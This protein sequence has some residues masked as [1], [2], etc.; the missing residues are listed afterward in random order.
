MT[1]IDTNEPAVAATPPS[2]PLAELARVLGVA[3][4]YWDWQGAHV[5]VSAETIVAVLAALG[6]QADTPQAVERGLRDA[7]LAPWRRTLPSCVLGRQSRSTRIPVH[8]PHGSAVVVWIETESRAGRRSVTQVEHHVPPRDVDGI[9]T[10][11]A[12]FEIPPGFPIGWHELHAQVGGEDQIHVPLMIV[13]ERLELPPHVETHGAFGL[14]TQMYAMRSRASWGIG[15]LGDLAD[16]TAW[17]A[18]DLGADFVLINP[19]H[20]AEPVAPMEPSPYLPTT[21]RFV[22]PIYI[23]VEDVAEVAYLPPGQRAVMEEYATQARALTQVDIIDRDACWDL[24]CRALRMVYGARRAPRRQLAFE[25]FCER[26]GQGLV[27]FATWCAFVEEYG[28]DPDAWPAGLEDA[29]GEAVEAERER[30]ADNVRFHMWLQWVVDHQLSEVQRQARAAGMSIGVMQDLAV[31]VHP[32][33]ADRWGLGDALARGVTVGAPPDPYNQRGQDWSQP[34]WRPDRL[35]DLGYEPFRAMIRAALRHSGALRIDHIIGLF[36]L[37]WVPEGLGPT[38][39]TYVRYDHEA[40]IGILVLEAQRAGAVVVGEDLGTVE[41]WVRDVLSERGI[42]GTSILWFEREDD[43]APKAPEDYRRLCLASVT[44][45][46][47]PPT[48]GYLAGEHIDVR[49]RLDLFT[50]PVEVERA[51]DEADRAR[52]LAV[53]RDRGLIHEDQSSARVVEALH[54][55]LSWTPSLLI[56]LSVPDLVGDLR[57]INQPGTHNEYPNWRLP[58]AGSDR[59]P[60]LLEELMAS[61]SVRRITRALQRG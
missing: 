6:V 41:P 12:M 56:G 35:A 30:L 18:H 36:R 45:H 47:L 3:T 59:R 13:P 8:V 16:L 22:N 5:V 17:G 27:D 44:T 40:L 4:E 1:S 60:V 46:D 33:G 11:E 19:V 48:A 58:V 25:M 61:R 7:D 23:R 31:G 28:V 49:A 52:M 26:E 43:G 9:L 38:H 10:G 2:G 55:Y 21:R 57:T 39:G 29:H 53:L 42:L 34:P 54:R 20:A 51:E 37:W 24:K 32:E 14:M 50:R 15:D